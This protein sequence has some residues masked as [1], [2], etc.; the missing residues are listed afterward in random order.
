MSHR[1]GFAILSCLYLLVLSTPSMAF[2]D[3]YK[4]ITPDEVKSKLENK[5]PMYLVDI[6]VEDDFAKHHLPG[7]IATYAYPVKS[8]A[9]KAKV[10]TIIEKLQAD[11]API[12]VVCPRGGGGAKRCY[13]HLKEKGIAEERLLILEKGQEGWPFEEMVEGN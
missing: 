9:E 12:V 5:D 2:L 11:D 6:Q 3:N 10:D 4:Y 13:D 1:F 8:D 7:A